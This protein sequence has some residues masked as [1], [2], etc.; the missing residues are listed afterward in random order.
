MEIRHLRAFATVAKL[1]S[2]VQAS[3]ALGYA[4]STITSQIQGLESDLGVRLFERLGHKVSLTANGNNL[5]PLAER[6]L[7]LTDEVHAQIRE[8]DHPAG[9]LVVGTGESLST[10]RLP[11]LLRRYRQRYPQVELVIRFANCLTL[12]QDL[13]ENTVDVGLFLDGPVRES[14]LVV[15]QAEDV[16]MTFLVSAEH[17][18]ATRPRVTPADLSD[19][20]LI[21]TE[22]GCSF[23]RW[24]EGMLA[25]HNVRPKSLLEVSSVE[26]IKQFVMLGLGLAMLPRFVADKELASGQMVP[27]VWN[28]PWPVYQ[29][30]I[31]VHKDKWLSP[32]LR[33]FIAMAKALNCPDGKPHLVS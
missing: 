28:G 29:T 9:R 4:Q 13:R 10:Y 15:H 21:I 30:Q 26:T 18:L 33:A 17:A 2:F 3:Q 6:I 27:V 8:P 1:G 14:D 19:H 25:G 11:E 7:S 23:R 12:R 32:A 20:C 22:P 16:E 5:L 24:L 31:V